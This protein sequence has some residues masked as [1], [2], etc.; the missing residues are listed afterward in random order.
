MQR[1][2]FTLIELIFVVVII[3]ILSVVLSPKIEQD[4]LQE[5]M[6]Q[7]IRHI[8]YTQHL[9]LSY[10]PY[11]ADSSQVNRYNSNVVQ[12]QKATQQWF[13]GWWQL[14][15]HVATNSYSVYADHPT[16]GGALEY[17]N[18]PDYST[19]VKLSDMIAKDP[20]TQQF[21]VRND[22]TAN[23]VPAGT[24]YEKVDLLSQYN[25]TINMPSCSSVSGIF[26]SSHILFDTL[27][28]PHCS[29]TKGDASL[30]PMDRLV[31]AQIRIEL[32]N[33]SAGNNEK[34]FICIEANSGYTHDCNS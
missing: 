13:K 8:R 2:A 9:A 3:G 17:G 32:Q 21:I 27:G 19:N 30:N 22:T 5:A 16:S 24:R 1:F 31:N 33:N 12:A 11:V 20:Q 34:R 25:V 14:Q 18:D 7:V 29:K 6:D 26:A 10:D 23:G 4:N 28:R 15:I